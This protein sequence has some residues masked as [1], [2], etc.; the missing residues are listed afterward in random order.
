[1]SL[2]RSK[3]EAMKAGDEM[4]LTSGSL[5]VTSQDFQAIVADL[6]QLDKV[7]LIRI[8]DR[9]HES[10]S[11]HRYTTLVKFRKVG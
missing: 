3:Y 9:K 8:I 7:A 1:M 2:A 10:Q 6:D 4:T 5:E 11:G